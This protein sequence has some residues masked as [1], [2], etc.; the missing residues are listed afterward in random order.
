MSNSKFYSYCPFNIYKINKII[1]KLLL[2]FIQCK[3]SIS[4]FNFFFIDHFFKEK[5]FN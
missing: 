1:N 3:V 2:Y 4:F 5:S